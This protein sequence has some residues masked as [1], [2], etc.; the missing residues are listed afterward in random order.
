M[1]MNAAGRGL[2]SVVSQA[3]LLA[4][5]EIQGRPSAETALLHAGQAGDRAALDQLLGL[6]ERRVLAVCRGILGHIE[7]AE[8]A[9][10]E[11]FFRALC[12]LPRFRGEASFRTWLLRI[13]VNVSLNWKRSRR[14]TEPWDEEQIDAPREAA[15]PEEIVLLRLQMTEA[16]DQLSPQRRA[17]L[18]L[19]EQEGWDV[20]EIGVAMGWNVKRVYNELFKAR[21]TLLEWQARTAEEEKS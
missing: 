4:V 9:A 8:D 15:S 21:Q 1:G 2:K 20:P 16:L 10:Q 18:L 5:D 19:R 3:G 13:A 11:T 17:V 12:A 14:L 7:D 6:H